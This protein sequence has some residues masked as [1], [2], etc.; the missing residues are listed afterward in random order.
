MRARETPPSL[1]PLVLSVFYFPRFH[2][3]SWGATRRSSRKGYLWLQDDSM[4]SYIVALVAALVFLANP[5]SQILFPRDPNLHKSSPGRRVTPR[6]KLDESLLAVDAPNATVLDCPPDTYVAR[7]LNREPLVVYL[8]GFLSDDERRH[9]L[10]ISEPL[11]E[12]STVTHDAHTEARDTTVRDSSVALV[13]RTDAVRCI[14]RRARAVQGWRRDTWVERLRTQRYHAPSGHYAHHFDWSGNVGGWGRVSSF[15]V[16]VDAE[17]LEGG[18]T[19]FPLLEAKVGEEGRD[20]W[21][22]V[23]E[24]DDT[25]GGESEAQKEEDEDTAKGVTFKVKPGNAVYW[26]NFALDGRGYQET[27]HAGLPVKKGTKVGLNIWNFG[28]IE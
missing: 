1:S 26:E 13:P 4:F 23:A 21:C 25:V 15:M 7:I 9:L 16:W 20:W 19:E 28:C 22:S 10:E 18:G 6:P 5:I 14:E 11:F 2:F 17:E 3:P 27:W 8:E 12:P 24:C